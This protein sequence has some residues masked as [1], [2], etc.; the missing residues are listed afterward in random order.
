MINNKKRQATVLYV[1][2]YPIDNILLS[3]TISFVMSSVNPH[4]VDLM[5]FSTID[6]IIND[7][8][9][10]GRGKQKNLSIADWI[11]FHTTFPHNFSQCTN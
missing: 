4:I 5:K 6:V 10:G 3:A 8:S 9:V 11:G 2:L 1:R 7:D